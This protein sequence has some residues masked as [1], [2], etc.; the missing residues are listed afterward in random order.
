M[1][2][3]PGAEEETDCDD[4]ERLSSDRERLARLYA[5]YVGG[6]DQNSSEA[7]DLHPQK[8]NIIKRADPDTARFVDPFLRGRTASL[9]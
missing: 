3:E 2:C 8:N 6:V 7:S 1:C 4:R 9:L 5:F